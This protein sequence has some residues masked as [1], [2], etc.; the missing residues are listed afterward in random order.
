MKLYHVHSRLKRALT[1]F[2]GL[3][4]FVSF[5]ASAY[6]AE[7]AQAPDT[8]EALLN[9]LNA[10]FG[11]DFHVIT[12]EEMKERY[13]IEISYY[14][15][16][17]MTKERLWK[18][19]AYFRHF[20]MVEIPKI[21]RKTQ[22]ALAISAFF[23]K[24]KQE[25]EEFT[26]RDAAKVTRATVV[27]EKAIDGATAGA[28]ATTYLDSFQHTLWE[29]CQSAYCRTNYQQARW[30]LSINPSVSI[31]DRDRNLYWQGTGDYGAYIN[32]QQVYLGSGTQYAYMYIDD[33]V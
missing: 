19:E 1:L 22:E 13:G 6:A 31:I 26:L 20:A 11:T 2:F 9:K 12:P 23:E 5:T 17:P 14:N 30:F 29:D 32:G 8:L 4:I 21:N 18:L 28:I 15:P 24:A 25:G 27:A 16:A 3:L 33:Y 10:E 7:Y